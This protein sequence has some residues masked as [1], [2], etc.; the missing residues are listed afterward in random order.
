MKKL[1]SMFAVAMCAT[2]GLTACGGAEEAKTETPQTGNQT[3]VK[4]GM[5]TDSGTIDDKSFNQGTWA[6]IQQYAAD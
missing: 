1:L 3:T 5:M 6:G 2:V 4:V